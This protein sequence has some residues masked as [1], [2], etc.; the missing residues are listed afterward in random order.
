MS[1]VV[2]LLCDHDPDEYRA[3]RELAEPGSTLGR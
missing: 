2:L 3:T 1:I